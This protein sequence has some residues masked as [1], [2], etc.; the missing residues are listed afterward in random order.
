[1]LC[2]HQ[3]DQTGAASRGSLTP[4]VCGRWRGVLIS[5]DA[6]IVLV[7][8]S[9]GSSEIAPNKARCSDCAG[10]EGFINAKRT[11]MGEPPCSLYLVALGV[12]CLRGFF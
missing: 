8:A 1:M 9:I 5:R 4:S 6:Q 3:A 2:E 7:E 12:L 10:G 11:G